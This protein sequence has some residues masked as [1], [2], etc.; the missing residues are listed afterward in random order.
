MDICEQC[1]LFAELMPHGRRLESGRRQD[2]C[3]ACGLRGEP[4]T[5]RAVLERLAPNADPGLIEAFIALA[6]R[7]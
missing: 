4:E 7:S 6:E 1:G 5:S 2:I 3:E